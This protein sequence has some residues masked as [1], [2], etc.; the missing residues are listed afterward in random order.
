MAT[1][2]PSDLLAARRDLDV[3]ARMSL[4]SAAKAPGK[5]PDVVKAA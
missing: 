1:D 3:E 2:F 5:L 4:I